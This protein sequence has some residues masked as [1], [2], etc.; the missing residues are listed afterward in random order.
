[1]SVQVI[2]EIGV[3]HNADFETAK[4]LIKAAAETGASIIKFQ[5]AIPSLVQTPNAPKANYQ[6]IQTGHQSSAME[7]TRSIHFPLETFVEL[8][9][10]VESFG[11]EFM[12]TA[13][14]LVSL[15]FLHKLGQKT[16]KIPSGEITNLRYLEAVANVADSVILSTGMA[17]LQEIE[18]AITVLLSNGISTS[19]L[20]V[21]HCNTAYPTPIMDANV[22]AMV[23]IREK[24]DVRVGYSDHTLGVAAAV[25]A[26]ANGAEII[27]KH[28]TLD[29][30][31]VGPDHA[32]SMEPE[33][34]KNMVGLI[35]EVHQSLGSKLKTPT[36]SELANRPIARRGLYF[37]SDLE[38]GTV[39]TIDHL[40]SLRPE[41]G[42]SPMLYRDLLGKKLRR[43][44][45]KFD[46]VCRDDTL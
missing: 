5:T 11:K 12:S 44:V 8:K 10:I 17:D 27:E 32:A 19:N 38:A 30:T 42:F 9:K 16:F 14:D 41:N 4:L 3:N 29:R 33:E 22:L 34:F 25:C 2:A 40:L 20:V 21:L 46:S 45:I 28:I 7:M 43:S 36:A 1:M 37:A 15:D 39:L 13:F 31:M 26:V 24:L 18:A 35:H 23:E 6:L